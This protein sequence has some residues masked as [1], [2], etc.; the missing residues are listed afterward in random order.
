MVTDEI[1]QAIDQEISRL[2]QARDL[3]GS[4]SGGSIQPTTVRR[5]RPPGKK[6]KP[7]S[8]E[9]RQRIGDARRKWARERK[10]KAA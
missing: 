3:L 10:L 8:P 2:T 4:I 1:L 9:S 5:G 6:R 7:M